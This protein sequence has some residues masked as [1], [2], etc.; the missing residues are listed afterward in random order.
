M[1]T[2]FSLTVAAIL[3]FFVGS[4]LNA[5]TWRFLRED[6]SI[7]HGRSQCPHCRHVLAPYDLIPV[8][9]FLLLLGKC[10]YCGKQIS[11]RY[12]L[13]ELGVAVASVLCVATFGV[14]WQALAILTYTFLLAA[15]FLLDLTYSI[16]PDS[17]TIPAFAIGIAVGI[18]AHRTWF[19]MVLGGVI[20]AG[21]FGLQYAVSRGHWIGSG[22]IRL[23]AAMGVALGWRNVL[24]ALLLA[25]CAGAVV[26]VILLV[27]HKKRMHSTIP[28]GVFLTLATFVVLLFGDVIVSSY[29]R[30]LTIPA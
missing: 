10:R 7:H 22:D 9:S 12:P 24:V 23:G 26:A 8:V 13:A 18:L 30:L 25:Y 3:G 2:P 19:T 16:L 1:A 27:T 29:L 14:T 11:W 4:F 21:F 28:F 5:F 6:V 17:V 15:L 20:G